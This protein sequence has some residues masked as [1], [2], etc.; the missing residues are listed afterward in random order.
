MDRNF[1]RISVK[2]TVVI[3]EAYHCYELHTKVY[4]IF[5]GHVHA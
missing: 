3:I 1:A 5:Q 4:P 2:L